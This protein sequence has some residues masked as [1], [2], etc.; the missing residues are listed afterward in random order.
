MYLDTDAIIVKNINLEQ[1]LAEAPYFKG[2]KDSEL[3]FL[4]S[5]PYH[6]EYPCSGVIIITNSDIAKKAIKYWW[7]Y[8][9]PEFDKKHAYE[10]EPLWSFVNSKDSNIEPYVGTID[11]L[12]FEP[13]EGQ[14]IRHV[15]TAHKE[16]RVPIFK[17]WYETLYNKETF[18]ETI[19]EIKKNNVKKVDII[20]LEQ[21]LQNTTI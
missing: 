1:Y 19:D 17:C 15:G 4:I 21:N 18:K 6:S 14:Y 20:N 7:N 12:S 16:R 2:N 5:K 8:D 9:M 3:K 13:K 11:E 10:Q